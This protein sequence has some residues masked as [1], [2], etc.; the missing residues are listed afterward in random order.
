MLIPMKI[1]LNKTCFLPRWIWGSFALPCSKHLSPRD[2]EAASVLQ[3]VEA[4]RRGGRAGKL[5]W[6]CPGATAARVKS[7]LLQAWA[8]LRCHQVPPRPTPTHCPACSCAGSGQQSPV[9]P[10]LPAG[11]LPVH[12]RL[13]PA[14]PRGLG[15]VSVSCGELHLW[16]RL[17]SVKEAI[18]KRG[19]E[20]N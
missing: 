13:C 3:N 6:S 18:R 10:A 2:T 8:G 16:W 20:L 11:Q 12:H 15:W 17:W 5:P 4:R 19:V 7:S 9:L 14:S 1:I